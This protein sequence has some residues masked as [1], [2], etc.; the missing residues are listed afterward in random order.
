MTF[1]SRIDKI[2]SAV[3]YSGLG[4]ITIGI[5]G[6][7]GGAG[8]QGPLFVGGLG[9]GMLFAGAQYEEKLEQG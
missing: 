7:V 2:M 9:F 5:F 1:Q 4:M 6:Y 8:V 3:K